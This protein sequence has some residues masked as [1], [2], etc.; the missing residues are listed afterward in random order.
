MK[1]GFDE[2][3]CPNESTF[4][5]II[6]ISITTEPKAASLHEPPASAKF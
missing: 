6:K 2:Q 3:D 1:N 4:I 5:V